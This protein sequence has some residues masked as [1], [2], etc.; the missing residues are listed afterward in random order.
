M[1]QESD[2]QAAKVR[3]FMAKK[4]RQEA[5]PDWAKWSKIFSWTMLA[6]F[7][8]ILA[9][10]SPIAGLSI[11]G[12]LVLMPVLPIVAAIVLVVVVLT[13]SSRPKTSL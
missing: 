5:A 8:V 11:L 6:L 4:A 2:F 3:F 13:F 10:A 12:I 1:S 7:T 9:W